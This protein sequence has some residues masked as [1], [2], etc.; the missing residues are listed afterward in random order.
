MNLNSNNKDEKIVV[1]REGWSGEEIAKQSSQIDEDEIQRLLKRGDESEGN[2]DDRD[3]A[4][5]AEKNDTPQ[6]REES[7]LNT[8]KQ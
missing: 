3:Y 5:N 2:P 7:K 6:G 4:G 1:S 8:E